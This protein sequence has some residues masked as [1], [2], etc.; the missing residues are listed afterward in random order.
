MAEPQ[1]VVVVLAHERDT[2]NNAR[3]NES[4]GSTPERGAEVL[5]RMYLRLAEHELLGRPAR[6]RV[7]IEADDA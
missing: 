5:G 3:F 7:T 1:K 2:K 6:I 4:H